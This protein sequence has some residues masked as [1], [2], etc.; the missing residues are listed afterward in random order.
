MEDTFNTTVTCVYNSLNA[1]LSWDKI[2]KTI[3][4]EVEKKREQNASVSEFAKLLFNIRIN[5]KLSY[6]STNIKALDRKKTATCVICHNTHPDRHVRDI[7]DLA[8]IKHDSINL[9][10]FLKSN[11]IKHIPRQGEARFTDC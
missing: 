1:G 4:P 8:L 9:L 10:P 3:Y 7:Y 2:E 5:S 6:I 11:I